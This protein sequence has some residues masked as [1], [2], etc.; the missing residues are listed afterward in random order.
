[1]TSPPTSCTTSSALFNG[2]TTATAS[3]ST[4][5]NQG[6]DPSNRV[7]Q[8]DPTKGDSLYGLL[9][10]GRQ[11]KNNTFGQER[12]LYDSLSSMGTSISSLGDGDCPQRQDYDSKEEWL[13][14]VLDAAT[15]DPPFSAFDDGEG[16]EIDTG[17]N[18]NQSQ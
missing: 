2:T 1:M 14:A 16:D 4:S 12:S 9:A 13:C 18:S 17:G 5:H 7:S 15:M 10:R 8:R 3:G 11:Q 6:Q